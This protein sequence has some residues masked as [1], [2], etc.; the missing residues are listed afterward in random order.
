MEFGFDGSVLVLN[1]KSTALAMFDKTDV[2]SSFKCGYSNGV[3]TAPDLHIF[4]QMAYVQKAQQR[5]GGYDR[6]VRF[7]KRKI[8]R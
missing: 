3:V 8:S 6:L 5:K 1:P 4:E 7:D 2:S